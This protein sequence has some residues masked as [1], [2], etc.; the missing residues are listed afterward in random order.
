MGIWTLTSDLEFGHHTLALILILIGNRWAWEGALGRWSRVWC[1]PSVEVSMATLKVATTRH[2]HTD[3]SLEIF[4]NPPTYQDYK[5]KTRKDVG[6]GTQKALDYSKQS[7]KKTGEKTWLQCHR[8]DPARKPPDANLPHMNTTNLHWHWLEF[9]FY[10]LSYIQPHL[11]S[12]EKFIVKY[13]FSNSP[14]FI[15]LFFL[16]GKQ[17]SMKPEHTVYL[18]WRIK[19]HLTPKIFL[20]ANK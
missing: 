19:V 12:N 9:N 5:I 8:K 6:K 20:V 17:W 11:S 13:F 14:F 4:T 18:A 10:S 15:V 3:K 7:R 2:C 16:G 1:K